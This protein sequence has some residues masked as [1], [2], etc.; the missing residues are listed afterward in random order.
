MCVPYKQISYIAGVTV[1][2]YLYIQIL[3]I[4]IMVLVL[5]EYLDC[6]G[7]VECIIMQESMFG[8]GRRCGFQ[9][10][11]LKYSVNWKQRVIRSRKIDIHMMITLNVQHSGAFDVSGYQFIPMRPEVEHKKQLV[12]VLFSEGVM[13]MLVFM[14][15]PDYVYRW[16]YLSSLAHDQLARNCTYMVHIY[17]DLETDRERERETHTLYCVAWSNCNSKSHCSGYLQDASP[18]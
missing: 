12:M 18:P 8:M 16:L 5:V 15:S 14:R 6:L 3:E 1:H 13:H 4:V 2:I 7:I 9:P 11:S 17:I 10:N